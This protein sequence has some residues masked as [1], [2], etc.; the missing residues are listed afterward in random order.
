MSCKACLQKGL[1]LVKMMHANGGTSIY[2]RHSYRNI[3]HQCRKPSS[4]S[5]TLLSRRY[6]SP[7]ILHVPSRH[8]ALATIVRSVLKIRYLV[9]G[10]AVGGG[11]QLSRV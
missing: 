9:L 6:P 10:S 1:I 4:N 11:V 5:Q 8:F 7:L 2:K 3:C